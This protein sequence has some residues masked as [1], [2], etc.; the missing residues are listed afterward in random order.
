MAYDNQVIQRSARSAINE[1][2]RTYMLKIYNY[3][4]G[5]LVLS[6]LVAYGISTSSEL[7]MAI[8]GSGFSWVA[9]F[10]PVIIVFVM[11]GRI[12]RMSVPAAQGTFWLYAA[13]VG[14]STS[15][16][17]AIYTNESIAK[18]FFITAGMFA[19]TSAYGYTTK[20]D[21][22]GFGGAF[23]MAVIGIIIASLVNL[24]L[25]S[26][27][28]DMMISFVTVI[29]FSGL[30]AYDTQ[31]LKDL[32]YAMQNRDSE[33]TERIAIF[34]ALSL[35]IDFINIFLSLLRLMGDRR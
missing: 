11:A 8:W 17:F 19:A 9:M 22:S 4:A 3:M 34:G 12:H 33:Q 35:F 27:A 29:V 31:N 28:F 18:V 7:M 15:V 14:V 21:L 32:F 26:S 5:A 13:S 24:F 6:G 16:I 10:A 25:K 2:L 20:R 30:V 23:M 1:A